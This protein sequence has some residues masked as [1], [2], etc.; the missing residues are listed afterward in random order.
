[1][2][3]QKT[4]GQQTEPYMPQPRLWFDPDKQ[5]ELRRL[6]RQGEPT[7][8]AIAETASG[9]AQARPGEIQP[10]SRIDAKAF[11]DGGLLTAWAVHVL[12]TGDSA[13]AD[14]THDHL[15]EWATTDAANLGRG[16]HCLVAAVC[17]QCCMNVWSPEQLAA[18]NRR[19]IDLHESFYTIGSG[20]DP[21]VVT[22]NHWG[23]SHG[24][25]LVAALAADGH[26]VEPG[27]PG[28]DLGEGIDWALNRLRAYLGQLGDQGFYHEGIGYGLYPASFWWAAVLAARRVGLADLL[29]EM[30]NLRRQAASM[31]AIATFSPMVDEDG[32]DQYR[33]GVRLSWNDDGTG[34]VQSN[35]AACM[36]AGA[37]AEQ[38]PA[39]RW[40]FD[41]L[42]GVQGDR[43][44]G[45]NWCGLFFSL[46]CYPYDVAPA[47][48]EGVLPR[49][50]C[51]WR[52]GMLID[53]NRFS[54][55][56]DTVLG[57]YARQTFLGGHKHDDAGSIRLLSLGRQWALGGGQ[58]RPDAEYQ[59]VFMPADASRA[60]N[61]L[62]KGAV[63]C[64]RA[65]AAGAVIGLDLRT[66]NQ[67]YCERWIACRH[68]HG[69]GAT[70]V[71]AV[72]DVAEDHR[73][74]PWSWNWT[75][76]QGIS[77]EVHCDGRGFSLIAPD[78]ANLQARLLGTQPRQIRLRKTPDSQRTF[79]NG[80]TVYYPGRPYVQALYDPQDPIGVYAVM[81]IRPDRPGRIEPGR[82][83]E[84]R[85]DGADWQR[86]FGASIPA[87][88][89]PGRSGILSRRPHGRPIDDE[90]GPAG[91]RRRRPMQ[92]T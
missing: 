75:F 15:L 6:W 85:I 52:Q 7:V 48:P 8:T 50:I 9:L 21:H 59:T 76:Q 31:Y 61:P 86:P 70:L 11:E 81:A 45:P 14:K 4:M 73:N 25:S 37:P 89:V 32:S 39:L 24:G 55:A 19:L 3:K 5:T 71:L 13:T 90:A 92:S 53:R 27:G 1:M 36:I 64:N 20:G 28:V 67:A 56:D 66:V 69:S 43:R 72:L 79:Q 62:G 46:V 80:T 18:V 83:L 2:Y 58:A 34:W 12:L 65:D 10:Q 78:G 51:D 49:H 68:D 88:F 33:T 16:T 41:R 60:S 26:A 82:G 42:N 47:R 84:V 57:V 38:V 44:F 17:Q 29:A 54:D 23:V 35:V 40:M 77:A 30:P 22:N 87:A 91:N 74:R 63:I